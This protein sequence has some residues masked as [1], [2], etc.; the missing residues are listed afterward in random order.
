MTIEEIRKNK[1]I[2]ATGYYEENGNLW[3][4]YIKRGRVIKLVQF[5]EFSEGWLKY[6]KYEI[7]PL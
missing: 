7:K 2:K 4:C 3:Y 6:F 5:M 1:P